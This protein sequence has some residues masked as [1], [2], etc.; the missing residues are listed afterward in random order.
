MTFKTLSQAKEKAERLSFIEPNW[1]FYVYLSTSANIYRLD[2]LGILY[3]DEKLL[4][5]YNKGEEI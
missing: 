5:T 2:N 4:A 3:S 1:F